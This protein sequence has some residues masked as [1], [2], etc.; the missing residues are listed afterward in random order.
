VV[1]LVVSLGFAF[2]Q[3]RA[4]EENRRWVAVR[5]EVERYI[6]E[7]EELYDLNPLRA[8]ALQG[9]AL[10][11]VEEYRAG[12]VIKKAEIW[13]EE[14]ETELRRTLAEMMNI[15][16]LE[17]AGVF[18]DLELVREGSEGDGLDFDGEELLVL[19]K[20]SEVVLAIKV[21]SKQ[22]EVVGGG[23]LLKGARLAAVYFGRGLVVAD[24][25]V[26]ELSLIA[27]TSAVVV[28]EDEVGGG[29]V[30]IDMFGGNLYF[31]DGKKGKIYKLAGIEGGFGSPQEWLG[32]GIEPDFSKV[33]AMAIDGDIWVLTSTG[34][35]EKYTRGVGVAVEI[36][37]LDVE[38]KE[39]K[40]IYTDEESERV[41]ILD[42]GNTRVVVADKDGVYQGQYQWSG[43]QNSS[44]MVVAEKE[45]KILL[46]SGSKIYE[47]Q[48][49][50]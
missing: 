27:K 37:G 47:I 49:E 28:D 30:A 21:D 43:I 6:K 31:L 16:L 24:T 29:V 3:Q 19:D 39:P 42:K 12:G 1:L 50:N 35:V 10:G 40:V 8:R 20:E 33:T 41:Y 15:T 46:L 2:R 7:S 4:S 11:L 38:L 17:E 44:D 36:Q 5:Q 26:V 13:M 23:V 18:L 48:I 14:T 22:A 32:A 25:G 34:K 45:G 9:E